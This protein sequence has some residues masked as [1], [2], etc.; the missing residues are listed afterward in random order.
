MLDIALQ[1]IVGHSPKFHPLACLEVL[2]DV[3]VFEE[4]LS[5]KFVPGNISPTSPIADHF[6][7]FLFMI[8]C[9]LMLLRKAKKKIISKLATKIPLFQDLGSTLLLVVPFCF[10]FLVEQI[11]NIFEV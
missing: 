2:L 8:I 1:K 6:K 9:P 4:R 10:N 11:S 5:K 7:H 3:T